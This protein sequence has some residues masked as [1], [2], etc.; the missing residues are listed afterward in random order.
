MN[1]QNENVLQEIDEALAQ[2]HGS[3]EKQSED[4]LQAAAKERERISRIGTVLRYIGV[5]VLMAATGAFMFQRW[6]D[7]T[8]TS[9]YF[10]FLAFTAGVCAAGLLCGL[11]IGENKGARTLL[12]AVV[13]LIPVHCAQ[14]GAVLFSR[15]G[16]GVQ[17]TDYPSYFFWSV[18]SLA[19]AVL[20]AVAGAVALVP[21]AY[22]AYSVLA[23]KHARQLMVLGCAVS[24]VLLVPTRDPLVVGLLMLVAG[25]VACVGEIKLSAVPELK[26]REAAVA[27]CVP[28][29]A[30]A[31]LIARQG[32]LYESSSLFQGL[33]CAFMSVVLFEIVPRIKTKQ[34]VIFFSEGA[35]LYTTGLSC[36]LISEAVLSG[37]ELH[38]TAVAPLVI[39]LPMTLAFAVMAERAR[40]TSRFFRTLS[41]VALFVTGLVELVDGVG[42]ESCII[43]LVIGIVAVTYACVSEQKG[44][45]FVGGA[46]TVISLGRVTILAIGSLSFSP[47]IIL[48]V[49]GVATIV[50]ASYLERNFTKL[51]EGVFS[52][53]KRVSAWR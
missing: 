52:A 49:I 2:E 6:E 39:G 40:Q 10:T 36:Y 18:P 3:L 8:H 38:G 53:R 16:G 21:M 17:A 4:R 45:L 42:I 13:V 31:M 28:F 29:I 44:L 43:A 41:A 11:K 23:R 48:G 47:W 46:L 22:T 20:V 32:A 35:A 5:A 24:S 12:G 7:M 1:T 30:T 26:T 14:I 37:F 50:A 25:V 51:R 33:A 15:L 19:D 9:R 34:S 27:R